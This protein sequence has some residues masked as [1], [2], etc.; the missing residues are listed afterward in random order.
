NYAWYR[1]YRN[2]DVYSLGHEA[3]DVGEFSMERLNAFNR[4]YLYAAE[5]KS[6]L[7]FYSAFFQAFPNA[8]HP[9]IGISHGVAWDNRGSDYENGEQFWHY[10]ERFIRSAEQLQKVVSVDTNTANWFQTVSYRTGQQMLT[11]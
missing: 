10:N 9:S 1:K 6:M 3:L 2:I 5:G 11:I 4:R 7:H 8:A